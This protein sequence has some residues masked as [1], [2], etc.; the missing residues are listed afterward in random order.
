MK[1]K[2]IAAVLLVISAGAGA[3]A[4]SVFS[5]HREAL[6]VQHAEIEEAWVALETELIERA[7]TAVQLAAAAAEIAP[8]SGLQIAEATEQLIQASSREQ[9]LAANHDLAEQLG[10]LLTAVE[11]RGLAPESPVRRLQDQLVS[12]DH[13][14]AERR[15]RYNRAVQDYNMRLQLFPGN[16]VAWLANLERESAYFRSTEAERQGAPAV[17]PAAQ[18]QVEEDGVE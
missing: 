17:R 6:R 11:E 9:K 12:A 16:A 7:R 8:K 13:Q 18:A 10:A 3:Y 1:T 14:I 4:I 15:R 2:L 5:E